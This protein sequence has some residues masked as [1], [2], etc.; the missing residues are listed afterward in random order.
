MDSITVD[1][2][3]AP[4]EPGDE[5]LLFGVGAQGTL[6]VEEAAAA[7]ET[8]AYELM[9]RVGNRVPRAYEG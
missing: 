1:V 4:V 9:V 2:G 3:D 6:P 5:A 7:A 8:I